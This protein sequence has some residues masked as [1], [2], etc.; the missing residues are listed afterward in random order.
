MFVLYGAAGLA[1]V[2]YG[3]RLLLGFAAPLPLN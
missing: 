2:V 3:S 1:L